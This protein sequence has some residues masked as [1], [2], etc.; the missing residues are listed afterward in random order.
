[1]RLLWQCE[2]NDMDKSYRK[3]QKKQ[4]K[5][6]FPM[7]QETIFSLYT[8]FFIELLRNLLEHQCNKDKRLL[9]DAK[10]LNNF[11]CKLSLN[12]VSNHGYYSV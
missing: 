2:R 10:N 6:N 3:M 11:N 8:V 5:N 1:M 4:F 9:K 12:S 7:K